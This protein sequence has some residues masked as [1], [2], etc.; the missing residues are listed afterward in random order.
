MALRNSG[1]CR[2]GVA[3]GPVDYSAGG[4]RKHT[5]AFDIQLICTWIRRD[6]LLVERRAEVSPRADSICGPQMPA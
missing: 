1:P 5:L 6:Y 3:K 4:L 2:L